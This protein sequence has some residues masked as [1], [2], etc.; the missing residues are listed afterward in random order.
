[1]IIYDVKC[2]NGHTFEGWFKDR[3]A[4]IEQNARRLICCPVCNSSQVE[5]APSSLTIMG[6]DSKMS[7]KKDAQDM[8][9]G[10]VL[11]ILHEYIEHHF[12][13]VGNKFAEVALKIH[14]GDEEKRNIKG[15]TT[16]QEEAVLK[17]EG[18]SFI[19]IPLPKMDS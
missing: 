3:Q 18:V 6:R 16:P 2:E 4:W 19:K 15:T 11:R 14:A 12:E 1:M 9:P 13:D 7:G 5:I 8:A 10:Q 17:E